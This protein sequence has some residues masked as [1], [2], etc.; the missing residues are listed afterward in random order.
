[1]VLSRGVFPV[2]FTRIS[3]PFTVRA[4]TGASDGVVGLDAIDDA[5]DGVALSDFGAINRS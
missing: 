2:G 5:A 1:M 4:T 3:S